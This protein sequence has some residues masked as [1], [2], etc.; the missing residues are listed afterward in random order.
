[1]VG[2]SW[3]SRLRFLGGRCSLRSAAVRHGI[4]TDSRHSE[5]KGYGDPVPEQTHLPQLPFD[6]PAANIVVSA[7]YQGRSIDDFVAALLAAGVTE[8]ADVRL[9]PWSR[10][11]GF[12]KTAMSTRLAT[13]GIGYRHFR[14]LGNP[15]YNRES[16]AGERI[17]LGLARFRELLES[18]QAVQALTELA[19][20]VTGKKVAVLCFEHDERACHRQLVLERLQTFLD[21]V[22]VE[23]LP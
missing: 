20:A 2:D 9:T 23:P 6:A 15:K 12:S 11:P 3:R 18:E 10:N 13:A 17:E 22:T 8:V 21:D 7:G 4:V 1:V 16:F 5:Q 19:S 14:A